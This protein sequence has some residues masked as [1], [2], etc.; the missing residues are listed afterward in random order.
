M[1]ELPRLSPRK[2]R[3][4]FLVSSIAF[5]RL[6]ECIFPRLYINKDVRLTSSKQKTMLRNRK[7]N[8]MAVSSAYDTKKNFPELWGISLPTIMH[9]SDANMIDDERIII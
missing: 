7:E 3:I 9:E 4:I 5:L 2:S 6:R 8:D 1:E